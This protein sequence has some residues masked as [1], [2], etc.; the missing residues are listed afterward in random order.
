MK[1]LKIKT[2][3]AIL[4]ILFLSIGHGYAQH[5]VGEVGKGPHG[6]TVQEADPNHAEILVKEG[7]V[8]IYILNGDAK[9]MNNTGVTGKALFQFEDGT[10]ISETL[11]TNGTDGFVVGNA[12]ATGYKNCIVTA[13]V[14]GKSISSKFKNYITAKPSVVTHHH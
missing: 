6:G 14:N 13:T 11:V 12:K 3:I 9:A 5:H 1:L 10:T 4:V 7:K 2:G 8:Y